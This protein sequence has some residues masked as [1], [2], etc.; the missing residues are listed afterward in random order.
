MADM[1]ELDRLVAGNLQSFEVDQLRQRRMTKS[2]REEYLN[3]TLGPAIA[4]ASNES[5]V[6]GNPAT[7]ITSK[8]VWLE[9]RRIHFAVIVSI[10]VGERRIDEKR[11]YWVDLNY[12]AGRSFRLMMPTV[13]H[14]DAFLVRLSEFMSFKIVPTAED[15]LKEQIRLA[16]QEAKSEQRQRRLEYLA[17]QQQ[18][19]LQDLVVVETVNAAANVWSAWNS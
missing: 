9:R 1:N 15:D 11:L 2:E 16:E 10:A 6:L 19:L 4:P 7:G 8:S 18:R 17:K 5:F 3:L 13:L 12:T 14:A